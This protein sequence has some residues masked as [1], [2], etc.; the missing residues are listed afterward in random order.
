MSL[1][2]GIDAVVFDVDGTLLHAND[3]GGVRGARLI[4]GAAE[5]VERVRASGRRVL[6]FTNG[7]GRPPVDYAADLRSV[8]LTL[9]DEEFMNPAVVAARYIARRHPGRSVLVLGGPGVVAPLEALGIETID[10]AD[11]TCADVVLVGWDDVLTY[12]A[13]R[14]AC[15]SIWAGAPLLATSTA[16]VFSVNGGPA[17]GWSG[18]IVAGIRQT[19]G[20]RVVTLGKPSPVALREM[21]R[22]LGVRAASTLIVGDDLELEIAMARRA[23]ARAALVLTGVATREAVASC[24]PARRPDAVLADV[25][26]L[27]L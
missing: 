13:L 26:E 20:A 1:L 6:F 17:P 11:R 4:A 24:P 5:T 10:A 27:L 9:A 19:T 15:D 14:A 3:P 21:C 23:G 12:S 18:A 25:T 16:T 2:D 7:T 22:T 8:G